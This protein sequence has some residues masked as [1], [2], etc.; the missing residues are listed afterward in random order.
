VVAAEPDL[1]LVRAGR[2]AA[3]DLDGSRRGPEVVRVRAT[4]TPVRRA[5]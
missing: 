4:V 3:T 5:G 2:A 1:P